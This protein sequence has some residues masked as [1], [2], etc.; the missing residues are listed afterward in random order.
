MQEDET[1][2]G[3]GEEARVGGWMVEELAGELAEG[4]EVGGV[5]G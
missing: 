3:V 2:D 1:F 5:H 4:L